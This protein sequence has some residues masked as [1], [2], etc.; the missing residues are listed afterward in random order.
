MWKVLGA[1]YH[2]QIAFGAAKDEK[3]SIAESL[4]L[5]A[6]SGESVKSRVAIWK[7]GMDTPTIY[8]GK[9][10]FY[11]FFCCCSAGPTSNTY[12]GCIVAHVSQANSNLRPS[13]TISRVSL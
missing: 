9:W 13:R 11:P 5:P 7:G 12:T 10:I 1:R 2:K 4:A 8:E 6:S 3:G